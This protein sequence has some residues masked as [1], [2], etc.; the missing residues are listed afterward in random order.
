MFNSLYLQILNLSLNRRNT[1]NISHILESFSPLG[2]PS[3]VSTENQ[4]TV[5]EN[6]PDN[7]SSTLYLA[8]KGLN[9]SIPDESLT[10]RHKSG[11]FK[12]ITDAFNMA[13]QRRWP[14]LKH[15]HVEISNSFNPNTKFDVDNAHTVPQ[16]KKKVKEGGIVQGHMVGAESDLTVLNYS[17]VDAISNALMA[18]KVSRG[19]LLGHTE[20]VS[21]S[22]PDTQFCLILAIPVDLTPGF[23]RMIRFI[24]Q[25]RPAG[26]SST[27][28]EIFGEGSCSLLALLS[29]SPGEEMV[30]SVGHRTHSACLSITPVIPPSPHLAH[31]L[32]PISTIFN[33]PSPLGTINPSLQLQELL[34]A[35][36]FAPGYPQSSPLGGWMQN[37][38]SRCFILPCNNKSSFTQSKT[39]LGHEQS[40]P[41]VLV[42]DECWEATHTTQVARQVLT[43]RANE[44]ERR[45]EQ[46]EDWLLEEKLRLG[47]FRSD[48]DAL[49]AGRVIFRVTVVRVTDLPWF[50]ESSS[51]LP[52]NLSKKNQASLD[53]SRRKDRGQNPKSLDSNLAGPCPFAVLDITSHANSQVLILGRSNTEYNTRDP[54]FGANASI[55]HCPMG[56]HPCTKPMSPH[57]CPSVIIDKYIQGQLLHS[58]SLEANHDLTSSTY[59]QLSDELHSPSSLVD[60]SADKESLKFIPLERLDS[61]GRSLSCCEWPEVFP[62]P[63]RV[64]LHPQHFDSSTNLR[65]RIRSEN[66]IYGRASKYNFDGDGGLLASGSIPIMDIAT[67]ALEDHVRSGAP[68]VRTFGKDIWVPLSTESTLDSIPLTS[69]SPSALIRVSITFPPELSTMDA[70][71]ECAQV[72]KKDLQLNPQPNQDFSLQWVKRFLK[73][74]NRV[75]RRLRQM[76]NSYKTHTSQTSGRFSASQLQSERYEEDVDGGY[77][78]D[79]EADEQEAEESKGYDF[80]SVLEPG[81]EN[82]MGDDIVDT[83]AAQ[84]IRLQT[85]IGPFKPSARK[86][87]PIVGALATNLHFQIL[88]VVPYFSL[89]HN[90][91]QLGE[92]AKTYLHSTR[93]CIHKWSSHDPYLL[94]FDWLVVDQVDQTSESVPSSSFYGTVTTGVPAAQVLKFRRGG[95][96]RFRNR[97]SELFANH[98]NML[99]EVDDMWHLA[100]QQLRYSHELYSSGRFAEASQVREEVK[101][102]Q[103]EASL[104]RKQV[105]ELRRQLESL[106]LELEERRS[107]VMSQAS[108]VVAAAVVMAINITISN[109][110]EG[111]SYHWYM[112]QLFIYKNFNDSI[113]SIRL[114]CFNCLIIFIYKASCCLECICRKVIVENYFVPTQKKKKDQLSDN[115]HAKFHFAHSSNP[116]SL[117]LQI[118]LFCF[119]IYI[120]TH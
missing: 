80:D 16:S 7:V 86:N 23:D 50:E 34:T 47:I 55:S 46:W 105:A 45:I 73:H 20:V 57:D 96:F 38:F 87:D 13:Q 54:V 66:R 61:R 59:P 70:F 14:E 67:M 116:F 9:I 98:G 84:K 85:P 27:T 33:A 6:S 60:L 19:G 40:S 11:M 42:R 75:I 91:V 43:W 52:T 83:E 68:M 107:L 90:Q 49:R 24:V 92:Q 51:Q 79:N 4:S 22:T 18:K 71:C 95:L 101:R 81:D 78:E 25:M 5:K 117:S 99:V 37:C 63:F 77:E 114:L 89:K 58:M 76:A 30:I 111:K 44:L 74:S 88:S 115:K 48:K 93:Q 112:L 100:K 3:V 110:V 53:R 103:T 64:C 28:T 106:H 56:V 12:R 26:K 10:Q 62:P 15:I 32:T 1:A 118:P 120:S 119:S 113:I 41:L 109:S 65:I 104:K 108:A 82:D 94:S 72:Q 21:G 31:A 35:Q 8:I 29:C 39:V 2:V 36:G 102:L 69:S 97:L 17:R